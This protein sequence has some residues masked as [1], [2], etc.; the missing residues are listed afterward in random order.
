MNYLL[1]RKEYFLY[2]TKN[3]PCS[4]E[5]N[6]KI[7]ITNFLKQVKNNKIPFYGA[8]LYVLSCAINEF[9]YFKFEFLKDI[10]DINEDNFKDCFKTIDKIHP[11]FTLLNKNKKFFVTYVEFQDNFENFIKDYKAQKVDFDGLCHKIP[12][13]NSFSVSILPWIEFN[14]FSLHLPKNKDYFMPIFTF[15]KYYEKNN[16][17]YIN[18]SSHFHHAIIDGYGASEILK[19]LQNKISSFKI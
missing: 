10:D 19:S 3:T 9:D 16:K 15:S 5:I 12:P 4:F 13:K 6:T 2:F 17:F 11:S 1:D 7:D 8:L 14:S 18:L